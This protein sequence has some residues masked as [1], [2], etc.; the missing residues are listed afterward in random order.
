MPFSDCPGLTTT[1]CVSRR[2]AGDETGAPSA[3]PFFK[4][5]GAGPA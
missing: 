5:T 4:Y 3:M 1:R 2:S